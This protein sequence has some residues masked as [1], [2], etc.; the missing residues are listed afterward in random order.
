M[1]GLHNKVSTPTCGDLD[2]RQLLAEL[3]S[4]QTPELCVHCHFNLLLS[5][6]QSCVI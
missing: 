1:P 5:V 2:D 4:K 6:M 3:I